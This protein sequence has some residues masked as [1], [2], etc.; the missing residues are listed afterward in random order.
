MSNSAGD[1]PRNR[2]PSGTVLAEWEDN[3]GVASRTQHRLAVGGAGEEFV[4]LHQT[5]GQRTGAAWRT[6]DTWEARNF[7]DILPGE[8]EQD[9]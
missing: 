6:K 3:G 5:R 8:S 4:I 2:R 1:T 7:P 9:E